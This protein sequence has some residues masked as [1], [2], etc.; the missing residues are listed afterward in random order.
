VLDTQLALLSQE[1]R[2][3]SNHGDMISSVISLYKGLGG[4]WQVPDVHN[5]IDEQTREQMKARTNWGDLLDEPLP[6]PPAS[7]ADVQ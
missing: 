1:D 6:Q 5:L 2:Y 4:G 7:P 3:L